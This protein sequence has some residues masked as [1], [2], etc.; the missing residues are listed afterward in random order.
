M[1][2]LLSVAFFS[3]SLFTSISV[4]PG[5]NRSYEEI[6]SELEG[7]SGIQRYELLMELC[8]Q[9]VYNDQELAKARGL[10]GLKIS[11]DLQNQQGIGKSYRCIGLSYHF[12][13]KTDSARYYYESAAS[14]SEDPLDK[15]WS[16]FNIAIIFQ[17]FGGYDST[18]YYLS[19]CEEIYET[20]GNEVDRADIQKAYGDLAS[21]NGNWP[22]ATE[23][24]IKAEAL[25]EKGGDDNRRADALKGLSYGYAANED[26]VATIDILRKA[27]SLYRK[28]NDKF[29]G[30]EALNNIGYNFHQLGK[31]DSALYYLEWSLD[32]AKSVNNSYVAGN[33]LQ[34][35]GVIYYKKE[36]F[37]QARK[38][39]VDAKT[40]FDS[41]GDPYEQAD[42]NRT[43]GDLERKAGKQRKAIEYYQKG[44]SISEGLDAQEISEFMYSGL[45]QS[46]EELGDYASSLNTYKIYNDIRDST[47][48]LKLNSRVNELL[49][50]Y[51]TLEKDKQLIEANA[52][53]EK[54]NTRI[55]MLGFGLVSILMMTVLGYYSITQKR[56]RER[57]SLIKEKE[58]ETIKRKS[59]EEQLEYKKKELTA[60]VLQ[61][62][63]KSEFLFSLQSEIDKLKS[64]VDNSVSQTS[65]K[66]TR[67][68]HND[69]IDDEN[70]EHFSKEFSS[71]H[72]E[73]MDKLKE[74][75]GGFSN[76]EWRL[77]ALMKM[78]LSSKDIANILRIS[79]E[80]VKKA[81]YR[82]RKKLALN[83]DVDIQDFLIGFS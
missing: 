4:L 10:E 33:C 52:A 70:W 51:E 23:R 61:L 72:Q 8:K 55:A 49:I 37:N 26:F 22:E 75:F 43:L 53:I 30:S 47:K 44:I 74:R 29:Y 7:S 77:I 25:Y 63:S 48:N 20:H 69:S 71:I 3:I 67:M 6:E 80:G 17:N 54:R 27:Y 28:T 82:L 64:S 78:N 41:K 11:Q 31:V 36:D 5:Q 66:I 81:R 15:A 59:A 46:Y 45:S 1:S 79:S 9:D 57:E 13:D 21:I 39:L 42:L 50:Q 19:L 65:R 16:Y 83:S 58:I 2:K 35:I 18:L 76:N 40:Y 73:F 56:K 14:Y 34:E 32:E 62:A 68:I 24:F 38:Y 60:K 12:I